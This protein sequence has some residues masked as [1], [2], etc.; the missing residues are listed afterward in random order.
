M[1][2]IICTVRTVLWYIMSL[3][4]TLMILVSLLTNKWVEGHLST[5][6]FESVGKL[7]LKD[8][9]KHVLISHLISENVADTVSGIFDNVKNGDIDSIQDAGKLAE[10]NIGLFKDCMVRKTSTS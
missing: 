5:V 4:G 8:E 6:N 10:K 2:T 9:N 7:I 1:C 3:A